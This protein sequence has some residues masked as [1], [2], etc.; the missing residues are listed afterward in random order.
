M[1]QQEGEREDGEGGRGREGG[2]EGGKEGGSDRASG[3]SGGSEGRRERESHQCL[4]QHTVLQIYT[5]NDKTT[6]TQSCNR[7]IR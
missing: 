5:D 4:S 1:E 3:E 6:L 2:E 7:Y